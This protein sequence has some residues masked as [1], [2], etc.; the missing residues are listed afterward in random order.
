MV[1]GLNV[2]PARFSKVA[3]I[4][5]MV[6]KATV[7]TTFL[8]ALSPMVFALLTGNAPPIMLALALTCLVT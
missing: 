3:L 2:F 7:V 6:T 1:R 5:V 4:G 8:P